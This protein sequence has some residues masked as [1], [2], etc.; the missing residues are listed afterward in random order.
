VDVAENFP[1]EC[2]YLQEMLGQVYLDDAE[3]RKRGLTPDQR[4]GFIG[5]AAGR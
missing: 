3:V 1:N 2:R 4:L 5:N